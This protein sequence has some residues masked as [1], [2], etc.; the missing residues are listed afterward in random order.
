MHTIKTDNLY[1]YMKIVEKS[2]L[3]K[4]KSPRGYSRDI[5]PERMI[6]KNKKSKFNLMKSKFK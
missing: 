4:L 1:I 3:K 2:K 6:G 5:T